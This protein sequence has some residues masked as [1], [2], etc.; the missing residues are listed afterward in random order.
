MKKNTDPSSSSLRG[1]AALFDDFERKELF[2]KYLFFLGWVE[3]LILAVCW[4]YQ[5]GDGGYDRFG[6]VDIPFPWRAYF[7]VAFLAPV[8]I[9]FLIGLVVVGFNKYFTAAE[10]EADKE[11]AFEIDGMEMAGDPS[12]RLQKI[13]RWVHF[14]RRLPFLALLLLLAIGAG[15]IYK[16]DA[17]LTFVAQVGEKSVKVFLISAIVL[18]AVGSI[19]ALILIVLNYQLRKRSMEY[20]YKSEVAERFGLI[21]LE[22]NT[23]LSREGKLLVSGKKWKENVPLLPGKASQE[24]P[25]G[26]TSSVTLTPTV[27]FK[28]S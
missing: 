8:A 9:T 3:V 2:K 23:V 10:A 15:F 24:S 27:D 25:T 6:P 21:I 12:G 14:L 16:L 28:T 20:Q 19:F 1:I 7:T 4:L 18:L 17:I 5:L 26:E 13:Y 22:D 11:H